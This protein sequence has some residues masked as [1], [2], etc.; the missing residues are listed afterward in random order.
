MKH[1]DQLYQAALTYKKLVEQQYEVTLFFSEPIDDK[2][3]RDT[4]KSNTKSNK[5]KISFDKSDFYHLT[6]IQHLSGLNWAGK[7]KADFLNDCYNRK[8][9]YCGAKIAGK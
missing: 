6:G 9:T 1:K 3:L 8:K 4:Y 5:I 7:H 2:K